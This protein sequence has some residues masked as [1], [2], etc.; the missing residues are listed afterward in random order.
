ML[1]TASEAEFCGQSRHAVCPEYAV[2]VPLPHERHASP[3]A[4]ALNLPA[5]HA[6]QR[7]A[8][9][10]IAPWNP[11]LHSQAETSALPVGAR[12]SGGHRAAT[13]R[14]HN[15][16]PSAALTRRVRRVDAMIT[17][18]VTASHPEW[19]PLAQVRGRLRRACN[20]FRTEEECQQAATA[21]CGWSAS[22]WQ[23]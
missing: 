8:L 10:V 1:P 4:A 9:S 23:A 22:C 11:A 20:K 16:A 5:S 18:Q 12:A 21:R 6:A 15:S 2:Y 14:A 19:H 13:P 17:R 3:P 7:D